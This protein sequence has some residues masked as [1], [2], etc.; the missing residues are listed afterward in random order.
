MLT[1]IPRAVVGRVNAEARPPRIDISN[2]RDDIV[3][4][5]TVQALAR[6]QAGVR[7]A[8]ETDNVVRIF[9]VIGEDWWTGLGNT[10]GTVSDR[11][12]E[13]G[14]RDIEVHVNSPGGD[15]FEGIAIYNLLQSHT[16]N[17]TVKVL[18]LAASAASIIAMCGDERL[19]GAGAFFMIH[20]AWVM[21]MGNR[22]DLRDVADYLEPFDASLRD[23][24]VARSSQSASDIEKWMDEETFLNASRSIELGF[25]TGGL[26]K[27][28][29]TEDKATTEQARTANAARQMEA[30][31]TKKGGM[32][33]SSAR[34]LMKDLVNGKPGAAAG[35]GG[36][37]GAATPSQ[38][39][40]GDTEALLAAASLLMTLKN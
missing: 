37:P 7:A 26:S 14:D 22:H 6:W 18:G 25:A 31:L 9:G 12:N 24:Y 15:V 30:V 36:M 20:N 17:V 11:L 8:V 32:T 29:V 21:A 10:V 3:G 4:T 16:K 27:D 1:N 5:P 38:P 19:I 23:I 2:P 35:H 40:A 39:G 28:D 13:I 34:A 33:R